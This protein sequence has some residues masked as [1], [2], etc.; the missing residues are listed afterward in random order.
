VS[1]R[2]GR[3]DP[4]ARKDGGPRGVR[5]AGRTR[6]AGALA[7]A[8]VL[9]L[10]AGCG[11]ST[12]KTR[13]IDAAAAAAAAK[14]RNHEIYEPENPQEVVRQ[15]VDQ[16]KVAVKVS[17]RIDASEK[18]ELVDACNEGFGGHEAPQV[19]VFTRSVCKE[20]ALLVPD[21]SKQAHERAFAE[22]YAKGT[23][24]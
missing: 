22:C 2:H 8:A 18:A 23:E 12:H 4:R 21:E 9:L 11:S 1:S 19:Y 13:T 14:Q 20:L 6:R 10:L 15:A 3:G 5:G 7:L 24:L 16:C 17:T